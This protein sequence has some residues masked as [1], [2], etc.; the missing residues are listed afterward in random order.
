MLKV[1][2]KIK[3]KTNSTKTFCINCMQQSNRWTRLQQPLNPRGKYGT[4]Q[5]NFHIPGHRQI[6]LQ[7]KT[8]YRIDTAS[9]G[10]NF[11]LRQESQMDPPAV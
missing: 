8:H 5:G 2:D 3:V 7:Y 9:L 6:L 10:S 11:L 1:E 4:L